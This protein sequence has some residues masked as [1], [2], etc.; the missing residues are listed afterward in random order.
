MQGSAQLLFI[1]KIKPDPMDTTL[2]ISDLI[3]T[4]SNADKAF[5]H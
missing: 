3:A 4:S 5:I 1:T 2:A